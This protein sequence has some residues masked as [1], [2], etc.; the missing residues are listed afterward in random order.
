MSIALRCWLSLALGLGIGFSLIS[1]GPGNE[2]KED[3]AWPL[4][5]LRRLGPLPPLPP[6]PT[7]R[8]ADGPAA[9]HYGLGWF[10]DKR[11]SGAGKVSCATYHVLHTVSCV[12]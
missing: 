11:P 9:A 2:P 5:L 3:Q 4:E 10:V 8:V 1:C 7:N 12:S 6:D